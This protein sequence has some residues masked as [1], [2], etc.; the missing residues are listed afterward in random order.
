[1][2]MEAQ[3]VKSVIIYTTPGCEGCSIMQRKLE[4]IVKSVD[5]IINNEIKVVVTN[6]INPKDIKH[7]H[8]ITD[9]PT[10]EFRFN[11]NI[12]AS[13]V[14]IIPYGELS[15]KFIKLINYDGHTK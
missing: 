1:M 15:Y 9:F 11:N 10:I 12:I 14:G 4:D 5:E 3:D 7:K 13:A 2:D 8:T 6:V